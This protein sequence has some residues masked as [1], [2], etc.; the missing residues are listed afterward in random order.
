MAESKKQ[1]LDP[2]G[3]SLSQKFVELRKACPEI[4]R[5]KHSD[6]VK[7]K[8][9]KIFD[10]YELL[11]PAMNEFG[12]DWDIVKEEATRHYDN[13]DAKF[14]DS[15][16]QHTRNGDRLVWVYEADLTL[17][18]I[19]VDNPEETREVTLHALGTN[20]GG[21][22]KAKGSAWTYCL[23]YYLFEKFNIDQGEDD[24]DNFDHSTDE[25]QPNGHTGA[26]G[27]SGGQTYRQTQQNA[28][29]GAQKGEKPLS[30][31][32]LTRMYRKGEDAGVTKEGVDAYIL[33]HF[34]L[35]EP[36]KMTRQ[37]YDEVCSKLDVQKAA[38]AQKGA[39]P[40]E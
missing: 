22:D 4:I 25:A 40:N 10:V 2:K 12:V 28:S 21:P 36:A 18:W 19:N 14:Y 34:N 8:F 37:Q 20:D 38:T 3:L 5:K 16:T 31:A 1:A 30:N 32:Q 33:K 24:P 6:G 39:Q 9:A 13:G 35:Q 23:K 17:R 15:Y 11:A 26:R 29:Q 27:G 7:Y